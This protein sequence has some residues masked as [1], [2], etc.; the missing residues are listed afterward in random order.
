MPFYR[1]EGY[2]RLCVFAT[3]EITQL[4]Y[5]IISISIIASILFSL[6]P[7]LRPVI[8]LHIC[9]SVQVFWLSLYP[10][11]NVI[12]KDTMFCLLSAVTFELNCFLSLSVYRIE[13]TSNQPF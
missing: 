1:K 5:A 3:K 4:C 6:G 11:R 9:S 7:N 2:Q 8:F 10:Y 12:P 13:T